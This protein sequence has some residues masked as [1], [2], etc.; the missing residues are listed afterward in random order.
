ML[1]LFLVKTLLAVVRTKSFRT[2]ADELGLSQPAVSQHIHK[3]EEE[4][5]VMLIQRERRGCK[6]TPAALA[7]LPFAESVLRLSERAEASVRSNQLRIGA[8]SNIGIYIL[9]PLLRS[10]LDAHPGLDVNVV[11]DRNPAIAARLETM[12]L[13]LALME[14]WD[15]RKGFNSLDWHREPVVLIVPPGHPL[16][17]RC[18]ITREELIGTPMLGGEP[19]TGTGRLLQTYFGH[20]AAPIVKMHLGSTEAVKQAVAAGLGISLV[21]AS[22]VRRETAAG[23]LRAIPFANPSPVKDLY[24]IWPEFIAPSDRPPAFVQHLLHNRCLSANVGK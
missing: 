1:N 23:E 2:A 16:G 10:F 13:D 4:L 18:T 3:L 7:F 22:A 24:A 17:R 15:G 11:V 8:G 21:L 6:P 9:Q 5:R 12:D 14:W 19:G 20:G